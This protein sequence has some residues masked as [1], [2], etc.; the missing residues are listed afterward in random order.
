MIKNPKFLS[1][2]I[3]IEVKKKLVVKLLSYDLLENF[4]KKSRLPV[5]VDIF[6]GFETIKCYN[7]KISVYFKC[8]ISCT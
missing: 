6:T 4:N 1:I 3:S 8:L 7:L 2:F 5:A